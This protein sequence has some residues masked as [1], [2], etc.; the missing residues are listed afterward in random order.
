MR[1]EIA[2]NENLYKIIY[3]NNIRPDDFIQKV[4]DDCM[5]IE[6]GKL[7]NF[8]FIRFPDWTPDYIE[9]KVDNFLK[10]KYEEGG[11]K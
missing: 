11:E 1:D 4:V 5:E 3:E 2:K 10:Y 8:L 7:M 9:E 6:K